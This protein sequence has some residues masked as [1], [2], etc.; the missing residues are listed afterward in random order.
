MCIIVGRMSTLLG[1]RIKEIRREKGLTQMDVEI[2]SRATGDKG[3]SHSYLVKLENQEVQISRRKLEA[4]ARGL[5]VPVWMLDAY[6]RGIDPD[7]PENIEQE[8]SLIGLRFGGITASENKRR[9]ADL[10]KMV[11]REIALLTEDKNN[12]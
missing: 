8:L 4:L 3:L 7:T 9:A 1:K 10:V 11:S 12:E 6:S 2:R 5:G